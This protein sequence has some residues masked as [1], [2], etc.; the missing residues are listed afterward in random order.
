MEKAPNGQVKPAVQLI[1]QDS[2]AMSIVA[3]CSRAMRDA[4]WLPD[5]VAA[6][7]EEALSGDYNHVLQTCM[8]FCD[9]N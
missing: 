8:T 3:R 2:N 1:G 5:E 6:F 7:S 9:V 4:G